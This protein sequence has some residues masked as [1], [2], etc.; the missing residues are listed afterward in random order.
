MYKSIK[1][2]IDNHRQALNCSDASKRANEKKIHKKNLKK[3]N[4][5]P[6]IIQYLCAL[7]TLIPALHSLVVIIAF[8]SNKRKKKTSEQN[9]EAK[10][11]T[12]IF[13]VIKVMPSQTMIMIVVLVVPRVLC[14]A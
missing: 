14:S 3:S 10:K 6:L 11:T 7:K 9:K 4:N 12:K 2:S 8:D 5:R 13:V 1:I